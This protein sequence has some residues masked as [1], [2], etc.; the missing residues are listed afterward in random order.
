M[1]I[2]YVIVWKSSLHGSIYFICIGYRVLGKEWSL[3]L[4]TLDKF[5]GL[6]ICCGIVGARNW[7][8]K[9]LWNSDWGCTTFSKTMSRD[10]FAQIMSFLRFDVKSER[11]VDVKWGF[12]DKLHSMTP[13]KTLIWETSAL[14]DPSSEQL[15]EILQV[16]LNDPT[17]RNS[18]KQSLIPSSPKKNENQFK[19]I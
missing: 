8:L 9:S 2:V 16:V 1:T 14:N 7:S 13:P 18:L 3:N 11:R 15:K 10:D 17:P 19:E 5:I 6:I 12:W 4:D